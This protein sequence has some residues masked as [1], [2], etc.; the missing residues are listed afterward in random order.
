MLINTTLSLKDL[1][2]PPPEKSGWPWTEQSE[3]LSEQR[4]DS[5]EWPRISIVTPSY[6]QGQFIE[7]TIRSVLLQGYPNLE[8][9]IID[10]GSKDVSIEIIKKYQPW[11]SFWKSEKDQGQSDAIN[12]GFAASTGAIMGW[13]NSDDLLTK[14]ALQYLGAAYKAGLNWWTGG[15]SQILQD[16]RVVYYN[17]TKLNTIS[18]RELLH[19]RAILFQVST[20]WTRELWERAGSCLSSLDFAMDYELWLRFSRWSSVIPIR[21]NLG[22]YRTHENAKTGTS[23]GMKLYTTECDVLRLEEYQRQGHIWL[24][25][26]ILITLWTRFSLAKAYGWRSCFGRRTIP[27]V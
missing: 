10:G 18:K 1:P 27:Y 16:G 24:I 2:L 26:A 3:P 15:A 25:R 19:A 8:Y 5:S 12:K 13:V 20:F 6:N 4:P 22:L 17:S 21:H 11:L 7:E 23:D 9:I 14:G